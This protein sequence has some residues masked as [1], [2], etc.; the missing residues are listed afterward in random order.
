MTAAQA[1]IFDSLRSGAAICFLIKRSGQTKKF[2]I[3]RQLTTGWFVSW[4]KF[5]EAFALRV[6]TADTGFADDLAQSSYLAYGVP[7][8]SSQIDLFEIAPDKRDKIPPNETSPAWKVFVERDDKER[9]T[10]S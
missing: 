3:V 6:A 2:T 7:D 4:D 10:V 1:R 5:R 8:T 9:F